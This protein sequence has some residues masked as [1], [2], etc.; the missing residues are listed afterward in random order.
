[1]IDKKAEILKS[2]RELF[3]TKGYKQTKVSDI[4]EMAGIGVGTFYNYYS[5]KE[6]LFLEIYSKDSED[7]KKRIEM[8]S[9]IINSI[10]Y[11]DLH[12]SEI[13]IQCFPQ[14]LYYITEFV[15]KGLADYPKQADASGYFFTQR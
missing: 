7:F 12:K 6:K 10:L 8:I 4:A 2:G 9:A 11:I 15:M 14:I 1:M 3:N 13:G 5:S